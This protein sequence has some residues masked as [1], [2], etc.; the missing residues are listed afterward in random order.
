MIGDT[1][2]Y[3]VTAAKASAAAFQK[4]GAEVV[5]VALDSPGHSAPL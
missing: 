2:G 4:D 3:G 5:Y 1:T